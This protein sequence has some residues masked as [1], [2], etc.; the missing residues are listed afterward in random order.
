MYQPVRGG[1]NEDDRER[2]GGDVLLE[3]EAAVH[4]EERVVLATHPLQELPV[5]DASP[6]AADNGIGVVAV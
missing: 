5:P 2:Q 3:L 6:A 1:T 4:G